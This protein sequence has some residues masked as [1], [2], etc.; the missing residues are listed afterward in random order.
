MIIKLVYSFENFLYW[1]PP[2]HFFIEINVFLEV[3]TV[4]KAIQR[5][6]VKT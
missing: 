3:T 6:V 5:M 4:Q 1:M 2:Q